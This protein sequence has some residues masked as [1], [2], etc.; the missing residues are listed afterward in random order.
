LRRRAF[1]V[2][3]GA[4]IA[5]GLP[6]ATRAQQSARRV[7]VL[8][9]SREG[10]A[11]YQAR[12]Q[13]LWQALQRLGWTVGQTVQ[14]DIR[15]GDGSKERIQ[16][17]APEL[18]SLAPDLVISSGS[19]ATAAMKR[20]TSS[21]PV[22]F[23]MVN[24]PVTQ[25]FVA[26]LAKPGGNLTGFTNV[27]FSVIGKA[28]ELLKTMVPALNRI[29]LMYNS[30]AYPIYDRYLHAL[31]S[32]GRG[33]VE[34]VRASVRAVAEIEPVVDALAGVPA[35]GVVVLADGGFTIA[36]RTT[37]QAALDRHRLPSIGPYRRFAQDGALMS[38]GPDELDIF[39]R[40]ADYVDRI[41]KGAK[42]A[43]LPVQQ[44]TKF[45]LVVNRQTAKALGIE[46]PPMLL[47]QADE[48]IE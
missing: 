6:F 42:P 39:S 28:V 43:D 7:A 38:Y 25:G 44:P 1:T 18:V 2:L 48:V 12:L 33:A 22:V 11:E 15:W 34:I 47:A 46:I 32:E 17:L 41:L 35:S 29:A 30:E 36:N 20:A 40:A 4:A 27:D 21:I 19:I 45:D 10:D 16:A 31:Q 9:P 14:F 13:A 3:L 5:S 37:I 8:L 24:E 26:S 23:V